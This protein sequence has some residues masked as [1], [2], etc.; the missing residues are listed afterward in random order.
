MRNC[1]KANYSKYRKE[2]LPGQTTGHILLASGKKLNS[3]ARLRLN[4]PAKPTWMAKSLQVKVSMQHL[5]RH[6]LV[7]SHY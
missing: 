7:M 6:R 1:N 4:P 5:S 3:V 2:T